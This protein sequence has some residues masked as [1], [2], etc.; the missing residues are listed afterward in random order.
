MSF[1]SKRRPTQNPHVK[2]QRV[3]GSIC[4]SRTTRGDGDVLINEG[5]EGML[6]NDISWVRQD[7]VND[8]GKFRENFPV[9]IPFAMFSGEFPDF[10][11]GS[12]A[13]GRKMR[14]FRPLLL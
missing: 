1:W 11:V 14:T 8:C 7:C 12:W 10:Q 6:L 13:K 4:N 5:G 3:V 9:A 2:L